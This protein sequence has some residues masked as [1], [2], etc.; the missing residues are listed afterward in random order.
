MSVPSSGLTAAEG[1]SSADIKDTTVTLPEGVVINPGQAAGL[2]ACQPAESAV[3]TREAPS[4][5]S[6]SKVGTD[7]IETPLLKNSLKGNVYV[8]QSNPPNLELLVAASGEGVNLK[9]VGHVHLDEAT[10]RLTTTFSN[11][12]ELPFTTFRLAFSGG[13]QAALATPARCGSYLT[14]SDFTPWGT[15]AVPNVFPFSSFEIL[16]G[17]GNSACP[18]ASLPFSPVLTAGST[19]DQAG[20]YSAFSLLLS[21]ADDQQRISKL[22]FTTPEGLLGMISKVPLCPEP[23]AA[24][25]T[26]SAA[27]QIGHTP[28]HGRSRPVPAGGPGTGSEPGA[29]LPDRRLQGRAATACRSWFR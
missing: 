14:T 23:Q 20:G 5:P 10:G 17:S 29:D 26:C 24:A 21:R 15:E 16:H 25:G 6:S 28:G 7:E 19:T 11:T 12:P 3:G 27:S 1:L 8:M 18:G 9:L 22:T 2:G 13:A 4:C